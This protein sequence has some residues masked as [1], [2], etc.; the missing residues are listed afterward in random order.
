VSAQSQ[1]ELAR[2]QARIAELERKIGKQQMD[3]KEL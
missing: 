2:A 1:L 3:L